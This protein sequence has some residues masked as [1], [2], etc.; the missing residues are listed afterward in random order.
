MLLSSSFLVLCLFSQVLLLN[1][2]WSPQFR[3]QVS[4]CRTYHIVCDVQSR[5]WLFWCIG[6]NNKQP[7]AVFHNVSIECFIGIASKFFLNLL[8]LFQW[9]Q[10]LPIW[11]YISWSTCVASLYANACILVSFL[12]PFFND[13]SVCWYCHIYQYACFLFFIFLFALTSLCV[14]LDSIGLLHFHVYIL[15]WM[16]VHTICLSLACIVPL[17]IE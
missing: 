5:L 17:H 1:Q 2:W 13:I 7:I 4:D 12:L 16:C 14:T 6:M 10:L 8:L 11:S 15:V 3:F 9:L